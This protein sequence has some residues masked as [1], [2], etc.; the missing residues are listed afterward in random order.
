VSN[1]DVS[2]WDGLSDSDAEARHARVTALR[3]ATAGSWPFLAQANDREDFANRLE[4][5]RP[6]LQATA[7]KYGSEDALPLVEAAYVN[8][9]E[10]LLWVRQEAQKTATNHPIGRQMSCKN[11]GGDI[12]YHGPGHGWLDRGGNQNC[13]TSGHGRHDGDGNPIAMPDTPHVPYDP[14]RWPGQSGPPGRA[15]A[16]LNKESMKFSQQH[17]ETLRA[18]VAPHDT[19]TA[20]DAYRS[21]NFPRADKVKDLDRR[22]RWDLY[23]ASGAHAK[24]QPYDHGYDDSHIETALKNVVPPLGHTAAQVKTAHDQ[25]VRTADGKMVGPGARVFDYYGGHWGTIGNVDSDES[26]HPV[27]RGPDKR[28]FDHHRDDGGKGYLNGE[29]VCTRIPAG[30]PFYK[31]HGGT[32][33]YGKTAARVGDAGPKVAANTVDMGSD[34]EN[35]VRVP[36]SHSDLVDHV[37]HGHGGVF[38]SDDINH[39]R[40]IAEGMSP[41]QLQAIH[42]WHLHPGHSHS[43]RGSGEVW[44]GSLNRYVSR[45]TADKAE[46]PRGKAKSSAWDPA[47]SERLEA[48]YN[49]GFE[50]EG[51]LECPAC[52]ETFFSEPQRLTHMAS[53]REASTWDQHGQVADYL[54]KRKPGPY[55]EL[56]DAPPEVMKRLDPDEY[57]AW[58]SARHQPKKSSI[59]V[60]GAATCPNCGNDTMADMATRDDK[61]RCPSCGYARSKTASVSTARTSLVSK[62]RQKLGERN[63]EKK[64][65]PY[66]GRSI[67]AKRLAHH[68]EEEH[69]HQAVPLDAEEKGKERKGK[70]RKHEGA[71]TDPTAPQDD[72]G[73]QGASQT[74]PTMSTPDATMTKSPDDIN[75]TAA[76]Q[77]VIDKI[78]MDIYHANPGIPEPHRIHLATETVRRYPGLLVQARGGADYV[79][80]ETLSDCPQCGKEALNTQTGACHN[81]G[82]QQKPG[83]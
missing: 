36:H 46:K 42:D 66:C 28:W 77:A 25:S 45:K 51:A 35:Q 21:G 65:C 1:L 9:F 53:H 11:C 30:N 78:A 26:S 6:R 75:R 63:P 83:A 69:P 49:H 80:G 15:Y 55:S 61:E 43:H 41:D 24:I 23:H 4:L 59:S 81:C 73:L 38:D 54:T 37:V 10:T 57:D 33:G 5:V 18:A 79:E 2:V 13:A 39:D 32:D 52:P 47:V 60:E 29:R 20:R 31:T 27:E 62:V 3:V 50:M 68:I 72:T 8:D 82:F 16:S 64:T 71:A 12:E 56:D 74:P 22:Y 19:P 58:Q 7:A 76:V 67:D 40:Q 17:L 34:W 44:S 14:E 48:L 70:G